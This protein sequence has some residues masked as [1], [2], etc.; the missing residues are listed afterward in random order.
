MLFNIFL[1]GTQNI[2]KID[3]FDA[4]T[5]ERM[6]EFMYAIKRPFSAA[7]DVRSAQKADQEAGTLSS[8]NGELSFRDIFE[9]IFEAEKKDMVERVNASRIADHYNVPAMAN[10]VQDEMKRIFRT[11]W[12]EGIFVEALKAVPANT[13]N[14]NLFDVLAEAAAKHIEL[15]TCH[16]DM[17]Q[18]MANPNF[19]VKL[20]NASAER[21]DELIDALKTKAEFLGSAENVHQHMEKCLKTLHDTKSCRQCKAKFCGHIEL[22]SR[23]YTVRCSECRTRH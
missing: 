21:T 7:A 16:D 12:Q 11:N 22:D 9:P 4:D 15:L 8:E 23:N 14:S 20:I 1:Q 5:V 3:N 6:I 19:A 18:L 10:V 13:A 17:A 2:F